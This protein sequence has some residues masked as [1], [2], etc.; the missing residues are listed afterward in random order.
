MHNAPYTEPPMNPLPPVVWLLV[1]PIVAIEVVVALGAAGLAGGAEGIAFRQEALTRFVYMPDMGRAM[2][3]AGEW[4]LGYLGRALSYAFVHGSFTHALMVAVFLL[5]LGKIVGE[6]FAGWA[7]AAV[8]LVSAAAGA[9]VYTLVPI[10][11]APLIGGY[12]AVYGLVGAFTWILWT[13]LGQQNAERGRAFSLIGMLLGVQ[14]VFGL[15]FG[16]GLDWIAEVAGFCAGFGL[17]FLVAPGGV[18]RALERLRRR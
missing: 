8:F 10:T 7:V 6:A 9:L 17:S 11:S 18:S 4:P 5:A 14:L 16:G 3:A 1:L 15:I 13:R 2:W 12:P